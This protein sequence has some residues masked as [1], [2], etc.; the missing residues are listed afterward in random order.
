MIFI[1]KVVNQYAKN[2]PTMHFNQ[3]AKS[4]IDS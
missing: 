3:G 4:E 1:D 2:T